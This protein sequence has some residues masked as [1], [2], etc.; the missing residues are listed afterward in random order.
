MKLYQLH[1]T[2]EAGESAGYR[3]FTNKR[4]AQ[5]AL[6][7]WRK[8]SPGDVLDQTGTIEPI[9]IDPTRRGI[10]AAL[11]AYANHADNG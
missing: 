4:E 2:H 1:L 5:S 6:A 10:C 7:T 9:E 8:N 3:Y 11:N